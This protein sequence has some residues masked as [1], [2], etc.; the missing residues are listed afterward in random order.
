MHNCLEHK[1]SPG[2]LYV[3]VNN[4]MLLWEVSVEGN[5]QTFERSSFFVI[6]ASGAYVKVMTTERS[7]H[8]IDTF[9]TI[10][11]AKLDH[12]TILQVK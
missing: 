5:T 6:S 8:I 9:T 7:G 2:D 4:G 1:V 3:Q 10:I 11:N 12:G